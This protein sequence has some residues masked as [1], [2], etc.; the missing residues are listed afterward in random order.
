MVISGYQTSVDTL[1]P[2][3]RF[4][5]SIQ[6]QNMGNADAERVTMILGGGSLSGGSVNGTPDPSGGVSGASGDFGNFAPV[7]SSNV[8]FIGNINQDSGFETNAE[9]IVNASTE[10]GAYPMKI[11][12]TYQDDRGISYTDDQI[13][14]LLVYAPPHLEVNFYR[15]PDPYFAGQPGMLPLQVLNLGKRTVVLGNLRVDAQ[16]AQFMN[17]VILV[18]ALDVGGYYT[19]DATI[20]PDSPGP[21]VLTIQIDYTDD[22]NQPREVTRTLEIM[23]EET[24]NPEPGPGFEGSGGEFYPEPLPAGPETILQKV[25]R[26]LRGLIGL[27]SGTPT[28]PPGEYPPG[29]TPPG[30]PPVENSVPIPSGKG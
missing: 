24:F 7:S 30:R 22:Y 12:F 1:T 23:V 18:G 2:G 14:T 10:P 27:D 19:L 16:D 26:L 20:I 11:S 4:A 17:N 15:P 3:T 6:T 9:L 5:L 8:Q 25:M 28:P 29:E 13:I 21:L